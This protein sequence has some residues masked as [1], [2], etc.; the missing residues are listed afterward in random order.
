LEL[1]DAKP[2]QNAKLRESSFD[3]P[4]IFRDRANGDLLVQQARQ[5]A[6][7]FENVQHPA[8]RCPDCG[9]VFFVPPAA[10]VLTRYYQDIYPASSISWSNVDADY[11]TARVKFRSE[12]ILKMSARYGFGQSDCYHEV[13]CAFG[14]TILEFE[15][16]G[17]TATGTDLNAD[18]VDQGR[19]RGNASIFSKSDLEFFQHS[20]VRPNVVY[21]FYTLERMADPL[22]YLR[23]LAPLLS[24]KSIVIMFV[25]NAMALFP[26]AYG[27][28]QYDWF[29]YP[30][31]LNMYSPHSALCLARAAG[32]DL[33]EVSTAISGLEPQAT[34]AIS[35]PR[36]ETPIT[37]ELREQMTNGGLFGEELAFVITPQGSPISSLY[38]TNTAATTGRCEAQREPELR[39]RRIG[40]TESMLSP[41]RAQTAQESL[42]ATQRHTYANWSMDTFGTQIPIPGV[43]FATSFPANSTWGNKAH[44][45]LLAIEVEY[46]DDL[47]IS[48]R[49]HNVEG[50]I[51]E[52]GV[53]E[54]WWTGH[55]F[56]ATERLEIQRPILGFDSFMGL[57]APHPEFDSSFWEEGTYSASRQIVETNIRVAERPRI[58]LIEGFFADSLLT[59]E[60]T[61]YSKI[62]FAR[63]DC[64][65][66]EPSCQ[67]LRYLANRL[68]HGSVLVLD[69]WPH[70]IDIGEGR[71]FAEWVP[72]VPHLKFEFLF[73]G[74]WGHLYIRVW[75]R[76]R[77]V[78][79]DGPA[80]VT[81]S[82]AIPSEPT[83]LRGQARAAGHKAFGRISK[84]LR[85]D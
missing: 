19:A 50:A 49:D 47:L 48:I 12:L 46:V 8:R 15:R 18:A 43:V 57:S 67:C 76:D 73:L 42:E 4:C 85:S 79:A 41:V 77:P 27:F 74:T 31:K 36:L 71:A 69:D 51:A 55:L 64:D 24:S 11:E 38:A 58:R 16:M 37:I 30:S 68:S 22:C 23:E 82:P 20:A 32:Y 54:G 2:P 9:H 63:V 75:H 65:I 13:G 33:L 10:D 6:R 28:D 52:F 39:I 34:S 60:A 61:A 53:F 59:D 17:Y 3:M 56:E 1:L 70:R 78:F 14:G 25:P 84:L 83:S 44:R 40:E 66:Y 80:V 21:G 26:T 81:S 29:S 72:N 5:Q 7:E 35:G 62:A 45:S